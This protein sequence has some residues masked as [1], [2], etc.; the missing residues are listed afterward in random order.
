MT[1]MSRISKAA[2]DELIT[3]AE[4]SN[5]TLPPTDVVKWARRNTESALHHC[6]DWDDSGAAAKYRVIQAHSFIATICITPPEVGAPTRAFVSIVGD[7]TNGGVMKDDLMAN[8]VLL[9]AIREVK[10][11][12][13]KYQ[14]LSD[15][16]DLHNLIEKTTRKLELSLEPEETWQISRQTIHRAGVGIGSIGE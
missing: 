12:S 3:S 7:C 6:F 13:F 14:H 15:L 16:R 5:T 1:P 11:W 2:Q 10:R 9:E 4:R 8:Q